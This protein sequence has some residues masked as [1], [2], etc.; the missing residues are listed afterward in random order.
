MP[1]VAVTRRRVRSWRYLPGFLWHAFVSQR[2]AQSAQGN[3]AVALLNDAN[4]AFWTC[5]MWRDQSD[6]R[7]FMADG[8]HRKAMPHLIAWCDE[9]AV[10][11]WEQETAA[12]PSWSEA[13]AR[14]KTEGRRSR[15]QHPSEAQTRFEIPPPRA[16]SANPGANRG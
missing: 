10:V 15:V 11:H 14:L 6:M 3:L 7:A 1:F 16:R 12:M 13:Y 2:Q 9:A 4:L 5:T 8:A